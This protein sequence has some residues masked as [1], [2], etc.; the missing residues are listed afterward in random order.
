VTEQTLHHHLLLGWL[1]LS[2]LVLPL[3]LSV[4]APYGRH[5]RSGWGPVLPA[6]LG[7]FLM[8]LPA[9]A[10]VPLCFLVSPR[11]PGLPELVLLGMWVLHYGHRALVY[12]LRLHAGSRPM[13]LTV[14]AMAFFFNLGNGYLNGRS[15]AVLAPLYPTAW[16]LDPRFLSGAALFLAGLALNLHSDSILLGLRRGEDGGYRIPEGGLFRL[17][18][19]PNYLGE[20]VEW[21][22]WALSTF[23]LPGLSF[24]AWTVANLLPRALANHRWYRRTFP[25]YPPERKALLPF[26]L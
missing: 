13:P 12:P 22:G 6:R 10:V 7:W 5:A 21:S 8:E 24:A 2:A 15:L 16:L 23:S 26:V 4:A 18:S 20:I 17:V 25:T 14:A 3:L 9:L 1:G 19:C 11:A